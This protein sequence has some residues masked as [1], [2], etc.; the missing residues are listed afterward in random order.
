MI[1]RCYLK[2]I[3]HYEARSGLWHWVCPTGKRVRVGDRA[4][5]ISKTGGYRYI[6]IHHKA[7]PESKLAVLYMTG[8]W[9]KHLVDHKNN[10]RADNRW[11][12][13]RKATYTQNNRNSKAKPNPT[14]FKGVSR[15]GS[16]FRM[17]IRVS[18][19]RLYTYGFSTAKAAHLAYVRAAKKHF[20]EFAH[21][22]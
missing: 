19:K 17:Q 9:P 13:L 1:T 2:R 14:G 10:K 20:G 7:Y 4:G 6:R 12:N 5:F 15:H 8:R 16:G 11:G 22:G 18:K 3:L 21:A